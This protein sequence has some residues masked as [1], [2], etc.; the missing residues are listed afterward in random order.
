MK[1][2]SQTLNNKSWKRQTACFKHARQFYENVVQIA[3][4]EDLRKRAAVLPS[5]W[6]WYLEKLGSAERA[7]VK[8]DENYRQH[9]LGTC[10]PLSHLSIERKLSV[11]DSRVDHAAASSGVSRRTMSLFAATGRIA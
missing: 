10:C 1:E 8:R 11:K 5:H 2:K 7:A 3:N 4:L 6:W 9:N